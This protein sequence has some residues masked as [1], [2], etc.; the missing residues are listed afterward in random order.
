MTSK[1]IDVTANMSLMCY[2]FE[3]GQEE[4]GIRVKRSSAEGRFVSVLRTCS[5]TQI[6]QIQEPKFTQGAFSNE[7]LPEFAARHP[8]FKCSRI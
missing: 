7:K 2:W 3:S 4:S 5:T 6:S 8:E 1:S